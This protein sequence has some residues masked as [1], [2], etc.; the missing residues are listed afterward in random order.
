MSD[1]FIFLYS[2]D[3]Y[4]KKLDTFEKIGALKNRVTV[5]VL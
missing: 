2:R 3:E 1:G 5:Q 4:I